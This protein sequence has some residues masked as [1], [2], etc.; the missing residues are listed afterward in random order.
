MALHSGILIDDKG[1]VVVPVINAGRVP[2]YWWPDNLRWCVGQDSYARSLI[3]GCGLATAGR[4]LAAPD[5]GSYLIHAS[6]MVPAEDW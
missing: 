5:L 2:L 6:D 3:V 1:C 4:I